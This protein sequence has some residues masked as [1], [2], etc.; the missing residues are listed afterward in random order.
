MKMREGGFR[1]E[2]CGGEKKKKRRRL[3]HTSALVYVLKQNVF[4]TPLCSSSSFQPC[5][6]K[7]FA[8]AINWASLDPEA[9][10]GC[11]SAT[12]LAEVCLDGVKFAMQKYCTRCRKIEE[13][14]K[15]E[16]EVRVME[17]IP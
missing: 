5:S 15:K 8:S 14:R 11:I 4:S 16:I 7:D 12:T 3:I 6:T 17:G 9:N 10:L 2:L 1:L 13:L